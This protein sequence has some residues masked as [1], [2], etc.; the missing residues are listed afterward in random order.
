MSYPQDFITYCD[1]LDL[2]LTSLRKEILF[3]LWHNHKKPLK[4]YDILENLLKTKLN[5]TPPNVYRTLDFFVDKGIIHKIESIQSYTICSGPIKNLLTEILMVCN[6]CNN[7]IETYD[8]TIHDL[9]KKISNKNLFSL[10]NNAIEIKGTCKDCD[11]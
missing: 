8:N 10:T 9:F 6:L 2:K 4:A 11:S 3:I 1:K 7:V 5:A